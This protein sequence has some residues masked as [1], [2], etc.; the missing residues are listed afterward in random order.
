MTLVSR[1]SIPRRPYLS[2]LYDNDLE[3]FPADEQYIKQQDIFLRRYDIL[4]GCVRIL[5]KYARQDQAMQQPNSDLDLLRSFI[6]LIEAERTRNNFQ[7]KRINDFTRQQERLEDR[8]SSLESLVMALRYDVGRNAEL[9]FM[10]YPYSLD[11]DPR[12]NY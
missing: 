8:V 4:D 7:D 9:E 6:D 10:E 3:V 5:V 1:V 12:C 11:G 2:R